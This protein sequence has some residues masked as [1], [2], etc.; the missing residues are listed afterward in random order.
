MC[1]VL[2]YLLIKR[3]IPTA[4]AYTKFQISQLLQ[5]KVDLSYLII[6]K[7]I[8]KKS[9]GDPGA[10]KDNVYKSKQAHVEL[11]KKMK[12]RDPATAPCIGDRV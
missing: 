12:V 1:N 5:N 4:I 8:T 3:D 7:G 9:K 2:D 10:T 6:S 11:A